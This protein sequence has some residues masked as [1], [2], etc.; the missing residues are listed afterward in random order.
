MAV[1]FPR[2]LPPVEYLKGLPEL[3][4]FTSQSKSANRLT[5]VVEYA[6]P[7]WGVTLS[8]RPLRPSD[9]RMVEAWWHS[10]REGLRAVDFRSPLYCTP[11][12]NIDARG[13]ETDPGIL[14]AIAS[15]NQ[16]TVTS[17]A[18]GLALS[19][20]DYVS[21]ERGAERAL[22]QI[23]D[24]S[25]S[26]TSRVI[27]IEPPLPSTITVNAVVRFDRAALIM[28]PVARSWSADDDQDLRSATFQLIESAK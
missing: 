15:G 2:L 17:V 27:E 19:A 13:P 7:L 14:S 4:R 6:D 24:V 21:F 26:G 11:R 3:Q 9:F 28:R 25:G 5:N 1:S 12:G 10:L 16:C 8:T 18:A 20:G 22:G 23:V